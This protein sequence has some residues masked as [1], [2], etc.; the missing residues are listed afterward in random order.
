MTTTEQRK[1]RKTA[2]AE[3]REDRNEDRNEDRKMATTTEVPEAVKTGAQFA[4]EVAFTGSA[5]LLKGDVKQFAIHG[6]LGFAAR[7]LFGLPGG[8]LI[9]ANSFVKATT[10][11]HLYEHLGLCKPSEKPSEKPAA[12]EPQSTAA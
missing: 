9:S 12:E 11:A 8:L 6:L 10:G 2:A 3:Q 7:S 4:S 5:N 1:E